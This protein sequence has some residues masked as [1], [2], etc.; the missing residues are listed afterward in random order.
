MSKIAEEQA[1][2]SSSELITDIMLIAKDL[3][4]SGMALI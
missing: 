3:T 4:I 2:H 1:T